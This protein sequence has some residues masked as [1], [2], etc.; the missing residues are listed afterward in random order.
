MLE[1]IA[2]TKEMKD[3]L[4]AGIDAFNQ[5][6]VKGELKGGKQPTGRTPLPP[7]LSSTPLLLCST[8]F[9]LS[10]LL[11]PGALRDTQA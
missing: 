7:A 6:P 9:D 4:Q 5:N 1:A 11:C 3:L 8:Q 10:Y 2:A